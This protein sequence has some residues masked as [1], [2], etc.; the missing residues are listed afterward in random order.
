MLNRNII[1][2]NAPL[3]KAFRYRDVF[4][5]VPIFYSS[6]A[7]ISAYAGHFPAFLEYEVENEADEVIGCEE[8]FRKKG[9]SEE[10]LSLGRKIPRQSR[11]R[12][13]I[14]HLLS[15]LTNFHF[16]EY[17]AEHNCW[18]IQAP[19]K[20]VDSLNEEELE[21]LNNQTS[22]WTIRSYVYP[23]HSQDLNIP[24]FTP[25][26]EYYEPCDN[27]RTYF[28]VN[29]NIANNPEIKFPPY[30]EYAFDRYFSLDEDERETV[31]QCIGLLYEGIELFDS[32][33][34]VSL[35]SIV[36]SIEGMAKLD[37]QKYGNGEQLGPT[38]RFLRYL[39]AFVAGKSEEK[40]R[41]YYEK[42]CEITHEGVLFL[43][44]ID[45]YGDIQ[46]QNEDW[47]LRLEILQA[48]RIALYNWLRQ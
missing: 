39:K 38:K 11:V 46:K 14:L 23:G 22:H 44:D 12:K 10:A 48:A 41:R 19:M 26:K 35:L 36:S 45:L 3:L 7:P 24:G 9:M 4:Q 20:N 43:S 16:F 28:T 13:E 42:R 33:R 40:F 47:L 37:L 30:L 25:C 6:Q 29:P 2:T 27:S 21:K 32:R 1:F 17:D 5:L 8:E 15:S 31:R 34:S 18:G